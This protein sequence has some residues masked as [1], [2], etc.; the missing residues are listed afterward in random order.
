MVGQHGFPFSFSRRPSAAGR[1]LEQV[2]QNARQPPDT[3]VARR[4]H[5]QGQPSGKKLARSGPA[6]GWSNQAPRL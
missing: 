2:L 4:F 5:A 3:A 1:M 6:R